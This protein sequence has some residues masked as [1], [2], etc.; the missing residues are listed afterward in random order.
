MFPQE[1][2]IRGTQHP[3]TTQP[4]EYH[5]SNYHPHEGQIKPASYLK[6][7]LKPESKTKGRWHRKFAFPFIR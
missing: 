6:P 5:S 3:N 1:T 4:N 7:K 2:V